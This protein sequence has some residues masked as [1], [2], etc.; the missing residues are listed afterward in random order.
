MKDKDKDK[1]LIIP[2]DAFEEEAS[3]GLGGLSREEAE[4][5]L[6]ELKGRME[7]RLRRPR[8][9]WL[10]A[11]AAVTVILVASALYVSVFR[12]RNSGMPRL[13][14]NEKAVNDSTLTAMA[15]RSKG[16]TAPMTG[17][18]K[19]N[20]DT[21]LIAMAGPIHKDEVS[22]DIRESSTG[23]EAARRPAGEKSI[24]HEEAAD[25]DV[26]AVV[27]EADN[28]LSDEVAVTAEEEAVTGKVIAEAMPRTEK[29][30]AEEVVVEAMPRA[31]MAA[32]PEKRINGVAAQA[33]KS[34]P[35]APAG[36]R[37]PAPVGGMD[38][39]TEW[40]EDNAEYPTEALPRTV[41][42]VVVIFRVRADST[43]YDLRAER[44][45]GDN[46]TAEAFR[47][48][49]EGPKWVPAVRDGLVADDEARV[50]IVFK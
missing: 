37:A 36:Y 16:E 29:A 2:G 4:A 9:I 21:A 5:D 12:E 25:S 46:F 13:A 35:A 1:R 11:A 33:P 50:S 8:M 42:E 3:E 47:L 44:T 41:Q 39:F 6:R 22:S 19:G 28:R 30:V 43:I 24:L 34:R 7:R 20:A 23:S 40:V 18:A 32:M 49:R 17:V 10:P 48:L 26:M 38:K 27:A 31:D 14:R 15:E 45:P